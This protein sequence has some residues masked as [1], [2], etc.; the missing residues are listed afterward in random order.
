[1]VK[2][3]YLITRADCGGAQIHVRDL[4]ANLPPECKPVLVTGEPGFLC[5]EASKLGVLVR[6][7]PDMVHLQNVSLKLAHRAIDSR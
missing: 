3:L 4:L 1:M 2:I 5:E 6:V 7:I